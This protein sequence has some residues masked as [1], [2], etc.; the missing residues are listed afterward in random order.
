M[1]QRTH[2]A[3][4]NF[5]QK[6][7]PHDIISETDKLVVTRTNTFTFFNDQQTLFKANELISTNEIGEPYQSQNWDFC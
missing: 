6:N 5:G 2:K 7:S 3:F 4:V 1:Q